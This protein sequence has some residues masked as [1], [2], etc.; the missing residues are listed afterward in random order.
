MAKSIKLSDRLQAIADYIENGAVVIDIGTDHGFLPVY[1]VQNGLA[2]R[3]IASD[4]SMGSLESARGSA[5]K[6]GVSDMITFTIASGLSGV[7][8]SM[9]D[10]VVVAGLGGESIAGI[11]AEAPWTKSRGIRLVLQPQSKT[12]ELCSFL[13]DSGYTL[14][15]AKLTLD[16][17]RIYVVL[18]VNGGGSDSTLEPE[19]ELIARLL[20]SGDPLL[21]VYLDGLIAISR[22]KLN[23]M[24]NSKVPEILEAALKLSTYLSMKEVYES[25]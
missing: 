23:G 20:H 16:N 4:I 2:D 10:T 24:K 13:R 19:L 17:D 12:G 22:K 11:L 7:D 9:V 18:L 25:M 5:R 8:E 14:K 1:L 6:H 15:G 3:V 21:G